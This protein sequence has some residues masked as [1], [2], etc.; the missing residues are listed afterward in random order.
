M[1]N[2][3]SEGRFYAAGRKCQ[4]GVKYQCDREV[5]VRDI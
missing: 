3:I 5:F 1:D 4:K 2:D